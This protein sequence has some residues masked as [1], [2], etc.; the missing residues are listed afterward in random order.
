LIPPFYQSIFTAFV[1]PVIMIIFLRY[2]QGDTSFYGW[3]ETLMIIVIS[4]CLFIAQVFQTKAFQ[5]DKAGRVA[6]VMQLQIIFNWVL[7]FFIIGTRPMPHEIV[8]GLLI[9]GSNLLVSALRALNLIK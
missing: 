8:G 2:R 1:S 3:Y 9:I 7:D 5:N 4:I 6:P